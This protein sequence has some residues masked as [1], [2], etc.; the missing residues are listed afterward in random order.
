MF[1]QNEYFD[2]KVASMALESAEGKATI[3]IMATGEYEFG[4]S[5][6]EIMTVI[7]GE[8]DIKMPGESE[9]KTYKKFES[10]TVEKDSRF[11][12][13]VAQDTPYMCVYK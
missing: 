1:Q 4:T 13:K 9:F 11:Y 3:G 12:V 8:M 10:F 6:V 5:T 7:S 2:G